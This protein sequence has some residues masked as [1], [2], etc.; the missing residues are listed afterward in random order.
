M[1]YLLFVGA[2]VG[3]ISTAHAQQ[4]TPTL[5]DHQAALETAI[6]QR[7]KLANEQLSAAA[8]TKRLIAAYEARLSTSLEWLKA[9]Q[10]KE[11]K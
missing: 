9:S 7:D 2:L 6:S 1:K 8:G 3:F 11:A 10:A 4:P 5:D